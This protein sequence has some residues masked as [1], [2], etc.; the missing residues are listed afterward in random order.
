MDTEIDNVEQYW[1]SKYFEVPKVAYI[2]ESL[3]FHPLGAFD[4]YNVNLEGCRMLILTMKK[5]SGRTN[6]VYCGIIGTV[7]EPTSNH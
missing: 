3:K 4:S 6:A 2:F 7:G 5:T 1:K